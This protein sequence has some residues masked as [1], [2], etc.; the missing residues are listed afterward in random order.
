ML[1]QTYEV[2]PNQRRV[3]LL[4]DPSGAS[5]EQGEVDAYL[6]AHD[7]SPKRQYTETRGDREYMVYY[8]GHCYIEDHL[9]KLGIIAGLPMH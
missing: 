3:V 1:M 7:L 4:F 9:V 8:F 2:A 6:K 5:R